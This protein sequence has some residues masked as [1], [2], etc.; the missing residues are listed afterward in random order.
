MDA[1]VAGG[2]GGGGTDNTDG[3]N[4]GTTPGPLGEWCSTELFLCMS[5]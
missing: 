4:Q 2:G 5:S 3:W 1:I